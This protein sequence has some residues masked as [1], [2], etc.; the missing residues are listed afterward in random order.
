MVTDAQVRLLRRKMS[1]K[2]TLQSAA[3]AAGMSERAARKWRKGPLPSETRKP[4]SWRTRTDPFADVWDA[5]VV[6]LLRGGD[7]GQRHAS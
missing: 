7:A 5:D 2:K 6:P 4:R 3:A 1:E